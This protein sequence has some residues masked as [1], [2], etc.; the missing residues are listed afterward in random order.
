MASGIK[1]GWGIVQDLVSKVAVL[2]DPDTPDVGAEAAADPEGWWQD[3][4]GEELGY[5][6]LLAG[7]APT[8]AARQGLLAGY[9]EPENAED[10]GKE[11]TAAHR[12][13]ARL[14]KRGNIRVILTTNFD[15][16]MERALEEI[17]IS[18]T[19]SATT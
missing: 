17:G 1:T 11:P 8:S 7:A 9:F 3:Q 10:T 16:L 12:A 5:S 6:R 2:H 4:F 14:V 19:W 15:R 13:I 18:P